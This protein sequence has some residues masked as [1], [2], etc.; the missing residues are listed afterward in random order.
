M[1]GL[2]FTLGTRDGIRDRISGDRCIRGHDGRLR[3]GVRDQRSLTVV[4]TGAALTTA[5]AATFPT[6]LAATFTAFT[7]TFTTLTAFAAAFATLALAI[8]PRGALGTCLGVVAIRGRRGVFGGA[9]FPARA[10]AITVG[11]RRALAVR[12]LGALGAALTT[13]LPVLTVTTFGAIAASLAAT[14]ATA[15]ATAAFTA[16]FLGRRFGC[17]CCRRGRLGCAAKESLEPTH[18]TTRTLLPK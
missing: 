12:T 10:L 9:T 11:A 13:A 14:T 2:V 7:T 15:V 5:F 4:G 8:S 3:G 17:R 16:L 1:S 18:E 6:S